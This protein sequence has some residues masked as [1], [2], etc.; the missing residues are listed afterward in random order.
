MLFARLVTQLCVELPAPAT[1]LLDRL[2]A[3][4][5]WF[6]DSRFFFVPVA[7]SLRL[8]CA[9]LEL[10]QQHFIGVWFP[11]DTTSSGS[12]GL[13]ATCV[14]VGACPALRKLVFSPPS[15]PGQ[16]TRSFNTMKSKDG[17]LELMP[18]AQIDKAGRIR[19]KFKNNKRT[20]WLERVLPLADLRSGVFPL[21]EFEQLKPTIGDLVV[22][23]RSAGVWLGPVVYPEAEEAR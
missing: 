11:V 20:D 6:E 13:Q 12:N 16:K 21:Q 15:A 7:L 8:L 10:L 19:A 2:Q 22:V 5:N 14:K 4:F 9:C 23:C 1:K 18:V 3:G 17:A